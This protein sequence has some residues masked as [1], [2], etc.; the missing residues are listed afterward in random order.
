MY[1][2]LFSFSTDS[3]IKGV[4]IGIQLDFEIHGLGGKVNDRT[5]ND[6]I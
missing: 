1:T 5:F 4:N 6:R 3:A 2:L